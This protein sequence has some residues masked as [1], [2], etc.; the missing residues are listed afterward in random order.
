MCDLHIQS[1]SLPTTNRKH[2][3]PEPGHFDG[4]YYEIV[5]RSNGCQGG[6]KVPTAANEN[7]GDSGCG[8]EMATGLR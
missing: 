4:I 3:C 1:R 8:G 6:V 5:L 7:A 2:S